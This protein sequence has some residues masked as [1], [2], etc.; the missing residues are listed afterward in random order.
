MNRGV[1]RTYN[2][3]VVEDLSVLDNIE[4]GNC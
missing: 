2:Q 4:E 3:A 1:K